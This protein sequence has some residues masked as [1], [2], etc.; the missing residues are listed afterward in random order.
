MKRKRAV[1]DNKTVWEE[2][3]RSNNCLARLTK[4]EDGV[5]AGLSLA[6][7]SRTLPKC[8]IMIIIE[9]SAGFLNECKDCGAEIFYIRRPHEYPSCW[10][11][12]RTRVCFRRE[13]N[14]KLTKY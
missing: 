5:Y 7:L 12:Y 3:R 14:V 11:N 1:S 6:R 4:Q 9:L 13:L 10:C 2:T 8:I